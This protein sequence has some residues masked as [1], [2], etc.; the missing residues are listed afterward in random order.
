MVLGPEEQATLDRWQRSTTVAAGLVRR[1][2]FLLLLA[3]G[4]SHTEV[5]RAVGVQARW[6]AS[7]PHACWP[8]VWMDSP[9][10]LAAGPRAVFPPAGAIH[11]VCLACERPEPV[12]RRLCPED[13]TE[14]ARQLMAEWPKSLP[15]PPNIGILNDDELY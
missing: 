1:G 10:P 6:S 13:W 2:N 5:G 15:W 9:T 4:H 12:G 3:A 8:S 7:G 14:R 11:V